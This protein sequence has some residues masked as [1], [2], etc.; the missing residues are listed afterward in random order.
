MPQLTFRLRFINIKMSSKQQKY[1]NKKH[2]Q[3]NFFHFSN[4][5][6]PK[7]VIST[8]IQLI[9]TFLKYSQS[10]MCVFF[11]CYIFVALLSL[12]TLS[13]KHKIQ[14]KN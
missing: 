8:D 14:K 5:L 11:S 10:K 2:Q 1:N 7:Y 4:M 9:E 3:Q 12:L 13:N 6:Q